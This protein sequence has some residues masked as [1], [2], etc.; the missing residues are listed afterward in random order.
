MSET[1]SIKDMHVVV[2]LGGERRSA[3]IAVDLARRIDAHLT[4]VALTIE[5]TY[6][7]YA[8]SAPI[9]TEYIVAAHDQAVADASAAAGAFTEVAKSAGI[10]FESRE[11]EPAILDGL[12]GAVR[13]FNLSDLVVVGQRDP[14]R[15]EPLRGELIE[16]ILFQAGAPA[17]IIPYTGVKAFNTKRALVAWDGS[18]TAAHA[19]RAALPLLG[20]AETVQ[21]LIV[22]EKQKQGTMTAAAA[23]GSYLSRHGIDVEVQHLGASGI[24]AGDT[25]LNYAADERADWLVMGAY[26]HSRLREFLLG[27]VT[28]KVLASM[29]LPVLMAH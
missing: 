9:P 28:R 11:S 14:D 19:V 18:A 17:L 26:G 15:A 22:N 25:I 12:L 3:S 7:A 1:G 10:A 24:D 27:G 2:D 29:T 6:P 8:M 20:L 21:V 23:I 4:G 5:P 16:S 13:Q